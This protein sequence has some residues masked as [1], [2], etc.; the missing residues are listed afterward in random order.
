MDARLL[1]QQKTDVFEIVKGGGLDP[2]AFE[3]MDRK[4]PHSVQYSVLQLRSEPSFYFEFDYVTHFLPHCSPW[5]DRRETRL[6]T[7]NWT[8]VLNYVSVWTQSLKN[9]LSTPDPWD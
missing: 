9:E 3:W 6:S 4:N 2:L 1:K 5:R 7:A 8:E